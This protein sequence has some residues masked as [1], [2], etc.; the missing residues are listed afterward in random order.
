MHMLAFCST[1]HCTPAPYAFYYAG[2]FDAG[3]HK[4][5]V[6]TSIYMDCTFIVK[7]LLVAQL[8]MPASGPIRF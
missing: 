5:T 4:T 3:L 8:A 6:L 1:W 2:I 7:S